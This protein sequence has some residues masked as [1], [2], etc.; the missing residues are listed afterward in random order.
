MIEV[1]FVLFNT[2][3]SILIGA[4]GFIMGYT[5]RAMREQENE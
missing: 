4:C 1:I 3:M 5:F 2:A